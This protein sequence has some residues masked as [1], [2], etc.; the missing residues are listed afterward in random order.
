M[1]GE[2][3][4]AFAYVLLQHEIYLLLGVIWYICTVS[5]VWEG[6]V[7]FQERYW[8][9]RWTSSLPDLYFTTVFSCPVQASERNR[10]KR[11]EFVG[12]GL[13]D[14]GETDCIK[15]EIKRISEIN[16]GKYRTEIIPVIWLTA[17]TQGRV[18][19]AGFTRSSVEPSVSSA[20]YTLFFLVTLRYYSVM[21]KCCL[22]RKAL[23]YLTLHW[24]WKEKYCLQRKEPI[25]LFVTYDT[26]NMFDRLG[27]SD[28]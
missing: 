8:P 2:S 17:S 6:H 7:P 3:F 14:L 18:L 13:F 26:P 16:G 24:D 11:P 19:W 22:K 5:A 25:V 28:T 9:L 10:H 27:I 12:R 15:E 4:C 20:C 1:L 23:S 21:Q